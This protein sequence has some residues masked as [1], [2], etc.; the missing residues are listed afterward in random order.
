MEGEST[1]GTQL[2]E[3]L[4]CGVCLDLLRQPKVLSCAH[5]F[6]QE[7]LQGLLDENGAGASG[8]ER[9]RE[10]LAS[11]REWDG[12]RRGG[13]ENGGSEGVGI[14]YKE[15]EC[16]SCRGITLVPGEG[17]QA[18][19]EPTRLVNLVDVASEEE[20]QR[21]R[22]EL[23]QRLTKS[24]NITDDILPQC[25]LHDKTQEYFCNQCTEL[26]CTQCMME[27]HRNHDYERAA[28]ALPARVAA[29][30]SQVQPAYAFVEKA[31]RMVE[32]LVQ[33]H[34]AILTNQTRCKENVRE[35]F[36]KL[37][38]ALE[39]RE[40]ALQLTIDKYTQDKVNAVTD[41]HHKLTKGKEKV[42]CCIESVSRLLE[43]AG[44]ISV[45]REDQALLEELD[46][47]QQLILEIDGE[48]ATAMHSSSYV[49]FSEDHIPVILRE[50][51]KAATLCEFYPEGDS[52][53]YASRKIAVE[54]GEEEGDH[55]LYDVLR[56]GGTLQYSRSLHH[57]KRPDVVRRQHQTP[58]IVVNVAQD[59]D[60]SES[61]TPTDSL[62]VSRRSSLS[63]ASSGVIDELSQSHLAL[64]NSV[65][66]NTPLRFSSLLSPLPIQEPLKVFDRLGGSR[67][68]SVHPCGLCIIA[69]DSM[70]V[71]DI[72][73]HCLR[74]IAS[75]GKFIDRIGGE[76]KGSGL[77][78]EPCG[79]CVDR[80][81][82]IMVTQRQNP[83]I[84]RFTASGKFVGKF[85]QKSLRGSNLSEPWSVCISNSG[86]IYVSDWDKSCIHIFQDSGRY[87]CIL[88]SKK[89]GA[90]VKESLLF[91]GG[92]TCDS[93]GRILVTDRGNHCVWLLQPDGTILSRFG[94]KGHAPGDLYYPYGIAVTADGRIVVSE[95]GNHRISVFSPS[96]Q[97]EH[98]FGQRGGQ[99]GFFD[100]P[101]HIAFTSRGKLVVVDETNERLQVFDL[102]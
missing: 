18:L 50:A 89:S 85:G 44:D 8:G 100:H 61:A 46:I 69:N 30:R 3:E 34:E 78:E 58:G 55:N 77:F 102:S 99:P 35:T 11:E 86:E 33:D 56:H 39:A 1:F 5:S 82:N 49:G 27:S 73:N 74:M 20:R 32:Q 72:K 22:K 42:L 4:V 7:C 64:S 15:I 17:M 91:P 76:G 57:T 6:C 40:Q 13:A 70:I 97:F 81:G 68:E 26:L 10:I 12:E 51:P 96:G 25:K 24:R 36:A 45:L 90:G 2:R 47:Q 75:N 66:P 41:H 83:R 9:V 87:L 28:Q 71:S 23:R 65:L 92:I 93:H 79:M 31:E 52:G 63:V 62:S 60:T 29:L 94:S 88:G 80:K 101:R 37:H 21:T 38:R 59:H 53:Y 98:C 84:Q 19:P 67:K 95:S 54:D 48:L 43:R 16:P 14:S